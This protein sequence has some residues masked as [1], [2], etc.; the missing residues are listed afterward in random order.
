VFEC[1]DLL[2]SSDGLLIASREATVRQRAQAIPLV[3][4]LSARD[5]W[6]Q[7]RGSIGRAAGVE[8]DPDLLDTWQA[9][10]LLE[11]QSSRIKRDP[12][13]RTAASIPRVPRAD[14]V[15]SGYFAWHNH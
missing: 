8:A 12:S 3:E 6:E 9:P 14:E 10:L 11:Q 1:D 15:H 13:C 2:T 4:A 7:A 5:R